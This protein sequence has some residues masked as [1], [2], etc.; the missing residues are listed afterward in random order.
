[1]RLAAPLSEP[2]TRAA[3]SGAAAQP[4]PS[5]PHMPRLPPLRA[6]L[7]TRQALALLVPPPRDVTAGARRNSALEE[8]RREVEL[9]REEAASP[10][11]AQRRTLR[12]LPLLHG[13]RAVP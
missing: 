5:S 3:T 6:K 13:S 1:M 4:A 12:L 9:E 2:G 10:S 7:L 8:L 11:G